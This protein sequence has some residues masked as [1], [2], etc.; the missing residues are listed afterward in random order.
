MSVESTTEEAPILHFD[1]S[2]WTS[3]EKALLA[4]IAFS[5]LDDDDYSHYLNDPQ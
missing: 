1:S 2:P 4:G 3:E 5:K